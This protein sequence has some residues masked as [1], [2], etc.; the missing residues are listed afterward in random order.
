[1]INRPA[2]TVMRASRQA[3]LSLL[4]IIE[5]ASDA[6]FRSVE[7]DLVADAPLQSPRTT[8][9]RT[10]VAGSSSP[11]PTNTTLYPSASSGSRSS[12]T[13]GTWSR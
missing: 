7:I 5:K 6:Q 1:M 11:L 3:D 12:T 8:R 2:R 13:T 10:A 4:G 9:T